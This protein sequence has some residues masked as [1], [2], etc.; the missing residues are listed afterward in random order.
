MFKLFDKVRNKYTKAEGYIDA[1]PGGG[2]YRIKIKCG[3]E[4]V[5]EWCYEYELEHINEQP[6]EEEKPSKTQKTKTDL[7]YLG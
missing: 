3:S 2:T 7:R 5:Y 6:A 1:M 4:Y